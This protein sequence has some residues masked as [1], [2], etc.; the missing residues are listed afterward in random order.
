MKG[1]GTAG[2]AAGLPTP[3]LEAPFPVD[4]RAGRRPEGREGGG[5]TAGRFGRGGGGGHLSLLGPS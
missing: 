1:I 3:A 2:S 4:P 5:R